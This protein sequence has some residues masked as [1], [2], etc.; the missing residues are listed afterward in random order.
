MAKTLV[1]QV[2]EHYGRYDFDAF[3]EADVISA[4]NKENL[5]FRDL[6]ALLSPAA[7]DLLEPMA[8]KARQITRRYFGNSVSLFTPIYLSNYCVNGCLYCG[9]NCRNNIKR[10]KLSPTEIDA[11]MLKIASGGF[12]EILILTGESKKHANIDYLRQGVQ[13]ARKHFTT[14]GLETYPLE[15]QEYALLQAAGADYVSVY[16]ETYNPVKYAQ[17]HVQGPKQDFEYRF[18]SQERALLG[19]MRGVSFGCLLGLDDYRQDAFITALHAYSIQ[20]KFP[21]AEIGFSVPRLRPFKNDTGLFALN[22]FEKH[23]L[24]VMLAYR[25]FL[26]FAGITISTR[27]RAL[28]RDNVLGLAATKVSASV[29]TGVG[30]HDAEAKG[31]EQFIIS[32]T[33]SVDQMAGRLKELGLQPVYVDY[34]RA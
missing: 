24:Q 20:R 32:D 3:G 25:L 23:L 33:R 17:V 34:V 28:F 5:D 6:A 13:L 16:Q 10:A 1:A 29:K 9:Y 11:E 15:E 19:G 14:I 27:E 7:L 31:E 2:M 30:G 4:I 22:V 26:P 12:R 21:M 18:N 8:Q